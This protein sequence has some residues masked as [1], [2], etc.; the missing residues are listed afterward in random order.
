[1]KRK[2]LSA[3]TLALSAAFAHAADGAAK[4]AA[5]GVPTLS[6]GIATQYIESSVR[7][8]ND[9]FTYLNGKWLK[10]VEIPSDQSSWGSFEQLYEDS[11]GQLRG[12]IEKAAAKH[13]VNG[14]DEQRI[15][16]YY[17]SFMDEA[18]LEQLGV[19][20]LSSEL[21]KIAAIKDKAELPALLAHLG[22]RGVNIPFDFAVHQ[23]NKDSTKYVADIG[24]G[25]LGMPDRDYY[26]KAD[27]AK[28][29][30]AK[31]KYQQHVAKV[32]GMSGD[33]NAATH[34][35]E[36]VDFETAIA[37]AQWTKVE[38]R[39]PIK[40]YNKVVLAD[41]AK[42]APGYDWQSY[43]QAT[44]IAAKASYVIVGQPTYLK[45]FAGIANATPLD[46]W[47]A[48]LSMH[49]IDSYA[50]Y[51]SKAYVDERFD[52]Y[53]KTLAGTPEIEARWKRG[54]ESVEGAEG[55]SLGKLYVAEYFP[56]ERK[57][58]MEA[59]VQNLL[60]AYKQSIDKLD[61]M[62]PATRK[63][64][65]AKLAKFTPKI[66]YPNK[67]RDYS[68]LVVVRDD[69]VGNVMRARE[70]EYKRQLNKLGTPVDR[71]EWDMT[72]QT[73]NAYY[74]PEKN[75]I[76]FPAAILQ[77]PFFDAQ[78]DDAVNYG[79]IGAVIGHEISHGF[80]DQ[81][82]QYDGDGNLRDWWTKADHKRFATK[83]GMLVK[84]YNAFEPVPGYHVNGE[85]TLG[86]N[87]ADN[88]GLAISY[89]AYHLSLKGKKAPVI[90][91][92]TGDQ[93]FYMG[94]AQAWRAKM[95]E[96]QRIV[97]VKV[98]PHSPEQFRANGTLKNQPGFYDAFGVKPG[99]K[100]YLAPK[101]RVIIW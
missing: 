39:D 63:E 89:K 100:M 5:T 58:R 86:E 61:W 79:A 72:P 84:Q 98:D 82:A 101:E 13:A 46:T 78:A 20:P 69:L 22:T 44:G 45:R 59:L 55:E 75:E 62:S 12:I 18:R 21:N 73:V 81:G 57:A 37:K 35:K 70:F 85:L 10:T 47:K 56:P 31:A 16:D 3:L 42:V 6:S 24:Q 97:M 19:T 64:A 53:G 67:W 14:T 8:Q 91:G 48:Y 88:S 9:F 7:P 80:D 99:D 36:I 4:T 76:V 51:L 74:N 25:G 77:E 43:L 90:D 28:L 41:M 60:A 17:A 33:Q 87:I 68:A 49:L 15:G 26:L 93:R 65:Q 71:D 94:W 95:R 38:L 1:M 66:G 2:A 27:D 52:F 34:A 32:L 29:A 92:L 83:T 54:V 40:A 96:A 50:R 30:E 23:D 11:L